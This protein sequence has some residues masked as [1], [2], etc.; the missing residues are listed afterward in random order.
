MDVPIKFELTRDGSV[1]E[2]RRSRLCLPTLEMVRDIGKALVKGPVV[3]RYVD[4]EGDDVTM[5]TEEEW[6]ECLK[7]W[8]GAGRVGAVR[9]RIDLPAPVA[10]E[11]SEKQVSAIT[12]ILKKLYGEDAMAAIAEGSA[13]FANS[14]WL[15]ITRLDN[16]EVDLD[17]QTKG[18]H[19][20]LHD[21]GLAS[22]RQ[23]DPE[24]IEYFKLCTE[25][26]ETVI[27]GW[28][29]LACSLI[30]VDLPSH[31]TPEAKEACVTRAITA[32]QRAIIAGYRKWNYLAS[33]PDLVPI[34]DH[35]KFTE[36]FPKEHLAKLH[37]RRATPA[38]KWGGL[39]A[40]KTFFG[41]NRPSVCRPGGRCQSEDCVYAR[42][43]VA[44]EHCCWECKD[45]LG[46]HGSRCARLPHVVSD[47]G[48][49]EEERQGEEGPDAL[50]EPVPYLP[51]APEVVYASQIESLK[52]MGF[53][54]DA[55]VL[56]VLVQNDGDLVQTLNT[57]FA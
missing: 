46:H 38:H 13:S 53:S 26:D 35:P 56:E 34:R 40:L 14:P 57:L 31:E 54:I 5:D 51:E 2:L 12:K 52:L 30:V 37:T 9:I 48:E 47:S 39:S 1:V 24:S 25:L 21:K 4:D 23:K 27:K 7:L 33:D 22:M 3:M 16:G 45:G 10:D 17:I 19:T 41:M 15:T 50:L 6:R 55:K 29:N 11:S 28:Y 42:T 32:L 36:L 44:P 8:E 43:G 20:H 49:E 18:L